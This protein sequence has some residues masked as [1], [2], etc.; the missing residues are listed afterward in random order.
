VET[1]AMK[2]D[3]VLDALKKASKGLLFPS[4]S[5]AKL[6]PF[7]WKDGDA[8]TP[9]RVLALA[10]LEPGTAV[11]TVTP[12]ELFATVPSEDR[13]KFQALRKVLEAQLKGIQ[14]Y[15]VGDEAEKV[16]FIAGKTADGRWAG[17]KTTVVE[18]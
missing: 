16:V 18:T 9:Q 14:V 17:L 7:A 8:L 4:E 2:K 12:D 10:E 6:E 13:A 11:E 5:E 3:S 15:K 1:D